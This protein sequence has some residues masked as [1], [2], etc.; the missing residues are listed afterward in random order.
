MYTLPQQLKTYTD[1]LGRL[2]LS[3]LEISA[4]Q[5]FTTKFGAL[6][7]HGPLGFDRN[8]LPA[9]FT[10]SAV[11]CTGD[12]SKILLTHHKKLGKWL[13]LGGHA[14]GHSALAEVAL[15]EA[16]EESGL[17]DVQ[18]TKPQGELFDIDI[19][20]IP[21]RG[22]L[23]EHFHYDARY[24]LTTNSP[25]KI[26]CSEESHALEWVDIQASDPASFE[27]GVARLLRRLKSAY[28]LGK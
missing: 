15:R 21:A 1:G 22:S 3:A 5:D 6:F 20:P 24:L 23:A 11:L 26:R 12:F 17:S 4:Q 19:H 27:P 9:H 14:D 10:A 7:E 13:Q 18:L 28:L 25:E 2:G 16:Q 8:T